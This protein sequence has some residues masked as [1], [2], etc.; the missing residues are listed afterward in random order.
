VT[1]ILSSSSNHDRP[2]PQRILY[3]HWAVA[4]LNSSSWTC[5]PLDS[6]AVMCTSD[7]IVRTLLNRA[8]VSFTTNLSGSLLMRFL[9]G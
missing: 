2:Q 8:F 5:I 4:R 7:R 6:G 9:G 3:M 1:N